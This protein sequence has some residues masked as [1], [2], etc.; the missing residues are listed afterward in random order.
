MPR[1][2]RLPGMNALL[3]MM[4]YEINF[5]RCNM[6]STNTFGSDGHLKLSADVAKAI[7][8]RFESIESFTSLQ[9][10]TLFGLLSEDVFPRPVYEQLIQEV[11]NK[12]DLDRDEDNADFVFLSATAKDVLA[13]TRKQTCDFFHNYIPGKLWN[14]LRKEGADI[15]YL[16]KIFAT[17]AAAI[18]L[19]HPKETTA[20]G[21]VAIL[22]W[23]GHIKWKEDHLAA[24]WEFK[25]H[26]Q[27]LRRRLAR[28]EREL[29]L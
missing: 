2:A 17:I 5:V 25:A 3:E 13:Q 9:A 15:R 28:E 24:L 4:L 11:N 1:L 26:L 12:T 23:L 22:V 14:D 29:P 20:A 8:K 6:G 7:I 27:T 16:I 18:H 19:W 10:N 21:I